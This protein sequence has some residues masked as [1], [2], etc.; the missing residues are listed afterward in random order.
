[1][2]SALSRDRTRNVLQHKP[3]QRLGDYHLVQ[4]RN[5][6]M[7]ELPVVVDLSRQVRIVLPGGL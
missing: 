2:M 5:V 3:H 6:R 7:D 1:M 4:A